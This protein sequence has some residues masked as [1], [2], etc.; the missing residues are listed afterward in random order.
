MAVWWVPQL[1]RDPTTAQ[2]AWIRAWP[3]DP[4]SPHLGPCKSQATASRILAP[5]A[6]A[7]DCLSSLG[8]CAPT[9]IPRRP[10]WVSP[11]CRVPRPRTS[12]SQSCMRR[13]VRR[14]LKHCMSKI[15][16]CDAKIETKSTTG[17]PISGPSTI[18][19]GSPRHRQRW[20]EKRMAESQG[21]SC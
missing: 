7:H 18:Q 17:T 10:V 2:G 9:A 14:L 13:L 4:R 12:Q 11:A 21:R 16:H 6:L 19:Q 8:L 5:C 1:N 3:S 15:N 20:V